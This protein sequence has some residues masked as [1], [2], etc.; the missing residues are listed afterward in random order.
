MGESESSVEKRMSGCLSAFSFVM[1][2][3]ACELPPSPSRPTRSSPSAMTS[4]ANFSISSRETGGLDARSA[5]PMKP[6][7]HSSASGEKS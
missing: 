5:Q 7:A 2:M 1:V 4:C 6:R 3:G